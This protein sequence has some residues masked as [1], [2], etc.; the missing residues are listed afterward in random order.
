MYTVYLSNKKNSIELE[1]LS[2]GKEEFWCVGTNLWFFFL[3]HV[4]ATMFTSGLFCCCHCWLMGVSVVVVS[5]DAL[6]KGPKPCVSVSLTAS[7]TSTV[8]E[9]IVCLL[10][11]LHASDCW[12]SHINAYITSQLVN[13]GDMMVEKVCPSQ[14]E[15]TWK[16]PQTFWNATEQC[17]TCTCPSSRQEI[18]WNKPYIWRVCLSVTKFTKIGFICNFFYLPQSYFIFCDLKSF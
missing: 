5:D 14:V 9:E 1:C 7:Y 17:L 11:T 16:R 18:V 13:I 12:N 4:D 15:K 10:R 2:F 3:N 8:A 6:R